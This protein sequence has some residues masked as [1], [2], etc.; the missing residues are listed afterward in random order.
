MG[1][2]VIVLRGLGGLIAAWVWFGGLCLGW[3]MALCF[4]M[5]LRV[6][7]L[8]GVGGWY[9]LL[10]ALLWDGFDVGGFVD[11][12]FW[13]GWFPVVWFFCLGCFRA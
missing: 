11:S 2:W 3:L 8:A 4:R 6:W 10:C 13:F 5:R 7:L 12:S 9:S 1:W